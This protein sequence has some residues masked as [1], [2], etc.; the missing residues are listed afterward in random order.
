MS[1]ES[2][3]AEDTEVLSIDD[4]SRRDAYTDVS[5]PIVR[6]LAIFDRILDLAEIDKVKMPPIDKWP[7]LIAKFD[8]VLTE[9]TGQ[10]AIYHKH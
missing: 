8:K 3:D 5:D 6:R 7:D 1:N 2:F 4:P 9:G 10:D